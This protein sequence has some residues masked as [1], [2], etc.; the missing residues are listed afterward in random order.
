M[1]AADLPPELPG[2][3]DTLGQDNVRALSVTLLIDLLTL[4]RDATR[5]AES[6]TTWTRSPR[7]C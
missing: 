1:A 3:M 6:P 5:A 2:W 4:E 7:T